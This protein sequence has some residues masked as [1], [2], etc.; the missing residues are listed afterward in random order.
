MENTWFHCGSLINLVV[1]QL[2]RVKS[3]MMVAPPPA[4]PYELMAQLMR[5][6][7]TT[8]RRNNDVRQASYMSTMGII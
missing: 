4:Q 7:G 2:T 8:I 5:L 3:E 1:N 6:T